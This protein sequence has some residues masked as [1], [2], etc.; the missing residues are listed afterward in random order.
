[1][2]KATIVVVEDN[3]LNMRLMHDILAVADFAVVGRRDGEGLCEV[4]AETN[5]LAVLMDI[6]LPRWSGVELRRFLAQD[7]RTRHI[8]VYAVTANCDPASMQLYQDSD[9][10][11]VFKKPL[12]VRDLLAEL[13]QLRQQ[14][15][16]PPV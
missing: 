7:E 14:A 9:F 11:G 4:V 10:A 12:K 8:P 5:P 2:S 13:A 6:Q 1:M 16:S 3:V 15:L